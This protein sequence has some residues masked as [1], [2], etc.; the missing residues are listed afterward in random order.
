MKTHR[1]ATRFATALLMT[2]LAGF[3]TFAQNAASSDAAASAAADIAALRADYEAGLKR[4]LKKYVAADDVAAAAEV[5][6]ELDRIA[7]A[8]SEPESGP[9]PLGT[10]KWIGYS[11]A[12][13]GSDGIVTSNGNKGIWKWTDRAE[14]K[15]RVSW[16]NG[17]VDDITVA[18]NGKTL[19]GVNNQQDKFVANFIEPEKKS[20]QTK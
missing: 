13:F 15:F 9:A 18:P 3:P 6:H 8:K 11:Y 20:Q 5:S 17:Y 12:I 4:L 14:G 1:P 7:P 2:A 16:V 10:W 19:H